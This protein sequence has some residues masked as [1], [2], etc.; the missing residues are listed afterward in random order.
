MSAASPTGHLLRFDGYELDVHT[1]ELRKN[2][3]KLRLQGQPLQVLATLVTRAGS[4]VT[5]EDLRTEIWPAD[6]FVDF[7]HS[8]H[9]AVARIRE[10]LGD[11]AQTPRYIET[12]PRRGYR[13]IGQVDGLVQGSSRPTQSAS[14]GF[15]D[16]CA[17]HSSNVPVAAGG[18][19]PLRSGN[20]TALAVLS[21]IVLLGVLLWQVRRR[22]P[23]SAGSN[24]PV[25]VA[26]LPF[27]NL[28]SAK[29]LDFLRLALPDEIVTTLS[30]AHSLSIRPFTTTSQYSAANL[31]LQRVGREMRVSTIVG[32]HYLKEGDH[33]RV[34]LEA[35]DVANDRTLWQET[36]NMPGTDLIAL[37]AEITEKVREG[38]VPVLG[39]SIENS[40]GGER[41]KN[42]EAYNLYLRSVSLS[43]DPEPNKE[44]VSMLERAVTLD[45]D[46]APAWSALG[47][48]YD[49]DSQYSAG[50]RD[51]LQRSTAALERALKLDPGSI[52]A[53]SW[54]ITNQTEKGELAKAYQEAKTLVNRRPEYGR[55]HFTLSYVLR[56]ASVLDESAQECETALLLDPGD[57][58]LRS[59]HWTFE[60]MGTPEKGMRFLHLDE[61]SVW[62]AGHLPITLLREGK[63]EEARESAKKTSGITLYRRLLKAWLADPPPA[64]LEQQARAAIPVFLADPDAE[65][66]YFAAGLMSYFGQEDLAARLMKSAIDGGYC[67]STGLEQDTLFSRLHTAPAYNELLSAAKQCRDNFLAQR[68]HFPH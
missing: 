59:C 31:D 5:R 49:Y 32:G 39:G 9:N 61:G 34:T 53:A 13:F 28:S 20:V 51:M 8:L 64:D 14:N 26:V 10:T 22:S 36:V 41:P 21:A 25:T 29:D 38:I 68:D 67:S 46:F 60:L 57:Y 19:R 56:Y 43:S 35:I 66:R 18:S 30:Y 1:G 58:Q 3:I 47:L 33:L 37:R 23:V 52:S 24:G 62:T 55:A 44:A 4:L 16:E 42:E 11:S 17:N 65:N 27:Q 45:P 54:L 50:G 15:Q 12:L 48:R 63:I 2:G 7:D 40:E 6:T